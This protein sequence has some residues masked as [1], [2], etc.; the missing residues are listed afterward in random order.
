MWYIHT[1]GYYYLAIKRREV[2][3]PAII[4]VHAY[5]I[6][7]VLSY[8]LWLYGLS[9]QASLSTGFSRQEPWSGLPYPP[10][11][12]LLDQGIK[13]ASFTSPALTGRFF[14]TCATWDAFTI[15]SQGLLSLESQLCSFSSHGTFWCLCLLICEMGV[16]LASQDGF[17]V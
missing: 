12:D 7:S 2:L 15:C 14:S 6:T 1:M 16:T 4:C 3:M 17:E 10:P 9:F 8:P 11:G 5:S 13:P